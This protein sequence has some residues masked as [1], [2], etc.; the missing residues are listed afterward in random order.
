MRQQRLGKHPKRGAPPARGWDG[1]PGSEGEVL[2]GRLAGGGGA[3]AGRWSQAA[4][5]PVKMVLP[6][7][8]G[9]LGVMP[10]PWDFLKLLSPVGWR[11]DGSW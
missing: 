10:L 9:S 1:Y 11:R 6:L 5:L 7:L 3:A 2:P 4:T 8:E